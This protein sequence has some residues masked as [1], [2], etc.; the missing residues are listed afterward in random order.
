MNFPLF[1]DRCLPHTE[2]S[3]P[4]MITRMLLPRFINTRRIECSADFNAERRV[5][6]FNGMAVVNRVDIKK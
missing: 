4:A 6:V 2:V 3:T 1:Q 5:I